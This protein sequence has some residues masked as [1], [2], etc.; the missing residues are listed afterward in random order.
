MELEDAMKKVLK[1]GGGLPLAIVCIASLLA[2]YK[3]LE[4]KY[5]WETDFK[6]IGTQMDSHPTLEGLR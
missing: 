6:S 2:S 4:S 5:M 1:K 3:S